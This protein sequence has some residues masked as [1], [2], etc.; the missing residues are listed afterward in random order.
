MLGKIEGRRRR[1]RQ[2]MRWLDGITNSMGMSLSKLWELM[3]DREA[4]HAAVHGVAKSRTW[5]SD[6]TEL[7]WVNSTGDLPKNFCLINGRAEI[8]IWIVWHLRLCFLFSLATPCG[9]QDLSS[10]T[11]DWT[12]TTAVK[13]QIHTRP[14]G[15][16]PESM[17]LMANVQDLLPWERRE[18]S[19]VREHEGNNR[20]CQDAGAFAL[21]TSWQVEGEKWEQ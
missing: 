8:W 16:S 2:R 6:W 20:N 7:N 12:Q 9:L 1:G 15:N 5:L 18:E 4:W 11:R 14:P 13:H 21:H 10:L 17:L 3:M 19:P